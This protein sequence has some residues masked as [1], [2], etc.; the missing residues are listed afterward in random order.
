MSALYYGC[1]VW[2]NINLEVLERVHKKFCKWV[3][4]VKQSTNTLAL[5]GELGQFPLYIERHV[6]MVKNLLKLKPSRL[7]IVKCS[8]IDK[9]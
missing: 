3:L 7:I 8:K 6:R 2:G 1:E 5:Y 9:R 4:N